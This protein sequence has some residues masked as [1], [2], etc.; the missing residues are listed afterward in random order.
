[1]VALA[2]RLGALDRRACRI[3]AEQ[4]FSAGVMADGYEQVYTRVIAEHQR[5]DRA[6]TCRART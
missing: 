5:T 6:L 2:P 4:R 1:L 3:E